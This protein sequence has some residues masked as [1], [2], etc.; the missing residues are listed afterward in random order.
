M[1]SENSSG[2][3]LDFSHGYKSA[4]FILFLVSILIFGIERKVFYRNGKSNLEKSG[5]PKSSKKYEI[6]LKIGT[7]TLCFGL[8]TIVAAVF[9]TTGFF[10]DGNLNQDEIIFPLNEVYFANFI[11]GTF[12]AAFEEEIFYRFYLPEAL[13]RNFKILSFEKLDSEK[14]KTLGIFFEIISVLVFAFSHR[15]LGFLAVLN[16]FFSGAILRFCMIKSKSVFVPATV[17]FS[18]N[19]CVFAAIRIL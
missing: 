1:V 17:H 3:V 18:Y 13:K 15:Y 8:I 14:S 2:T 19:F 12:C 5:A 6:I 11:F 16:A 9:E 7:G 4:V 10:I